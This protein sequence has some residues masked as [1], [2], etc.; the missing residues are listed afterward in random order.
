MCGFLTDRVQHV[1]HAWDICFEIC[2]CNA[3]QWKVM[4]KTMKTAW[5]PKIPIDSLG[6]PSM[7]LPFFHRFSGYLVPV[8]SCSSGFSSGFSQA[9]GTAPW[10]PRS[11]LK[12]ASLTL[13]PEWPWQGPS[14]STRSLLGP[15]GPG[16]ARG[17]LCSVAESWGWKAYPD[18]NQIYDICKFVWISFCI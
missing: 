1:F 12:W 8:A 10:I 7:F 11:W 3:A 18:P 2:P 16:M 17:K 4:K 15:V 6:F 5:N 13:G 14:N 9:I